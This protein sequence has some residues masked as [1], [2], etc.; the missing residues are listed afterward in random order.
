M[1]KKNCLILLNVLKA[2]NLIHKFA[3]LYLE[4]QSNPKVS[5]YYSRLKTLVVTLVHLHVRETVYELFSL[6]KMLF[7]GMIL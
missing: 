1:K 5:L 6:L 2:T 4:L 7:M 3:I